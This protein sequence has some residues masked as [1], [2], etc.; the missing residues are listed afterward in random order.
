MFNNNDGLVNEIRDRFAHVDTC[1]EQG[2]RISF[3]NSRDAL[4]LKSLV[5][6]STELSAVPDNQGRDN[7][8][9]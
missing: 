8:A 4:T 6:R 2:D 1:L 5:E 9:S 3:E 7:V